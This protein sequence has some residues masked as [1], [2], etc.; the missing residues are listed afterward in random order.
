MRLL[1]CTLTVALAAMNAIFDKSYADEHT[2]SREQKNS[3]QTVGLMVPSDLK[4]YYLELAGDDPFRRAAVLQWLDGVD[5]LDTENGCVDLVA[6]YIDDRFESILCEDMEV[7]PQDLENLVHFPEITRLQFERS[8]I[9]EEV[10]AIIK[11]HQT[12]EELYIHEDC[13]IGNPICKAVEKLSKLWCLSIQDS[14]IDDNGLLHLADMPSLIDV[15]LSG[16]KRITP[17]GIRHI[18]RIH[19][20]RNFSI[21]ETELD[22][23]GLE[24]LAVA[25][26][27]KGL[28]FTS[29]KITDESFRHIAALVNLESLTIESS[30]QIS[31][32]GFSHLFALKNPRS[33]CFY[34]IPITDQSVEVFSEFPTLGR[35]YIEGSKVTNESVPL[36]GKLPKLYDLSL[37]NTA[38][39]DGC[40]PYFEAYTQKTI[41]TLDIRGARISREGAVKIKAALKE[42]A[43]LKC[44]Y[45]HLTEQLEGN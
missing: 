37:R 7:S 27:L 33:F 44:D 42:S 29:S 11:K 32:A 25:T 9:T 24:Y 23:E 30:V 5:V 14:K 31:I 43:I 18:A 12:L 36:F 1:V 35:L 15:Y 19:K 28:G 34:R 13:E 40:V 41:S 6:N 38:I 26:S 4:E 45:G 39:D 22:N 16:N 21:G 3:K 10:L 17:I 2:S 8:P 20:L